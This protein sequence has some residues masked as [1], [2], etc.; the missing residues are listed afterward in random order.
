L[1]KA[2]IIHNRSAGAGKTSKKELL[3]L[4]SRHNIQCEYASSK[5][6]KWK[7]FYKKSDL[8]VIS[9]GDGTIRKVFAELIKE[10]R[11]EKYKIVILPHGTANN[12]AFSLQIQEN[13]K[14]IIKKIDRVKPKD[15]SYGVIS[16]IKEHFFVESVGF[17]IF[18][19]VITGMK[20]YDAKLEDHPEERKLA[21]LRVFKKIIK[22]HKSKKYKIVADGVDYSGE[23]IMIEI[24]NIKSL[25][26]NVVL[27]PDANSNDRFLNLLLLKNEHRPLFLKY[28]HSLSQKKQLQFPVKSILC[29]KIYI[30]SDDKEI[31]VDDKFL[32]TKKNIQ[33]KIQLKISIVSIL[34]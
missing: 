32:K 27:C 15:F 14:S 6:K 16:N 29:K 12:I 28:I 21:S 30:K 26:A 4:F 3:D 1:K 25:G 10:G 31:H 34:N 8:I 22:S 9:G 20:E 5:K 23:Y 33:I 13:A 24:M 11:D 17:G 19:K 18:P 2:I 7:K